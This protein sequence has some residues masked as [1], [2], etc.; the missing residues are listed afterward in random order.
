MKKIPPLI[1][2]ALAALLAVAPA[3][4]A[5]KPVTVLLAGGAE[6]NSIEIKLSADGRS[7]VI[8]SAGPLEVGG[9]VC[10]NPVGLPNE[11]VCQAS[12]ISGFAVNAG[13]GN[14]R[15][16]LGREVQVPVTLRGGG[17][18]DALLGGSAG[19]SLYGGPGNDL[20][21]GRFGSDSLFGG[22]GNDRLLGGAGNDLLRGGPGSDALFGGSGNND[23]VQ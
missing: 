8:D 22:E 7:F 4:A 11:L 9:T 5:E 21:V 3:W 19:D 2:I 6:D 23:L 13:A 16:V 10:A 18:D 17:G 12:A 14:D 20:L 15:V 1:A